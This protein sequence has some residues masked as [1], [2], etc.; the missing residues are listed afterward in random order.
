MGERR[1]KHKGSED[2]QV[3]G[4]N[5]EAEEEKGLSG[6]NVAGVSG[7]YSGYLWGVFGV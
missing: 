4:K 7:N 3:R 5:E 1:Q 2:G 6:K